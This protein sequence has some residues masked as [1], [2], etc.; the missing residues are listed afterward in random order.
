MNEIVVDP[1]ERG[2]GIGTRLPEELASYAEQNGYDTIRLD[3]IDTN[4]GA[5]RKYERNDFAVGKTEHF[6]YLR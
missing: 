6:G 3:V 4:P 5:R 1:N 2:Q